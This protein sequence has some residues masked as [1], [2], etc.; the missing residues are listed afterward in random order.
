[1]PSGSGT[2]IVLIF[3]YVDPTD[4]LQQGLP[5]NNANPAVSAEGTEVV[6]DTS[7]D[8]LHL[9]LPGRQLVMSQR[10]SLSVTPL[11]KDPTGTASNP[12]TDGLGRTIAFESTGD[13]ANTGN[14]A[15]RQI[16]VLQSG[17][18]FKQ[19]SSGVGTS[20][21]PTLSA[22]HSLIAFESTSDPTTGA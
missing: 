12:A 5:G 10:G 11:T 8:P 7:D 19:M 14:A 18:S 16:F 13:L 4:Q 21:N 22:L 3:P 20:R 2:Q 17:G 6:W 15:P 1:V 9:G